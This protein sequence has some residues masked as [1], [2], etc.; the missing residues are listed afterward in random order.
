M[1]DKISVK[2]EVETTIVCDCG[3]DGCTGY[4]WRELELQIETN[5]SSPSFISDISKALKNFG[6]NES[7]A[8]SIEVYP[9]VVSLD[10]SELKQDGVTVN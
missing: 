10:I 2:F 3:R 6:V 8:R 4:A 1:T 7:N 9:H 5:A